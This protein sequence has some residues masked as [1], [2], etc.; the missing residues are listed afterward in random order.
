MMKRIGLAVLAA[1]AGLCAQERI[2]VVGDSITGHAMNLADG[3]KRQFDAALAAAGVAE[4]AVQLVPLGGSGQRTSTWPSILSDTRTSFALDIAS[5]DVPAELD[6]GCDKLVV[7]LG[8]NDMIFHEVTADNTETFAANLQ[9]LIDRLRART[10]FKSLY[11]ATPTFYGEEPETYCNKVMDTLASVVVPQVAAANGA[12]VIDVRAAF[13]AWWRTGRMGGDGFRMTSD[14]VHPNGAGHFAIALALLRGL[15]FAEAAENWE[16]TKAAAYFGD[17]A[18]GAPGFSAYVGQTGGTLTFKGFAN[19]RL[20]SVGVAGWTPEQAVDGT[21]FEIAVPAVWH[22]A[23]YSFKLKATFEDGATATRTF[24]V[25][26]PWRVKTGVDDYAQHDDYSYNHPAKGFHA[27]A[28]SAH[29]LAYDAA[30]VAGRAF[31]DI[32]P[33]ARPYWPNADH[34]GNGTDSLDFTTMTASRRLETCYAM[35]RLAVGTAQ[36]VKVTVA[37]KAQSGAQRLVAFLDGR[38]ILAASLATGQAAEVEVEMAAGE[39]EFVLKAVQATNGFQASVAFS[40]AFGAVA[41]AAS[42][43]GDP[44]PMLCRGGDEV[45]AFDGFNVHRFRK[46]GALTVLRGGTVELLLVGGGGGGSGS[47][48]CSGGGGGGGVLHLGQVRLEA[49][50]YAVCVGAGGASDANGGDT[51][52]AGFAAVGGGSGGGA[53][54]AGAAGGSGGGASGVASPTVTA[55]YAGGGAAEG[56]GF[57]GGAS[58]ASEPSANL[59]RY[60]AGGGGGAGGAG[61]DSDPATRT[62][63]SG[64]A[65]RA[66]TQFNAAGAEEWFAAGGGGGGSYRKSVKAGAGGQGGGGAGAYGM[67]VN[68]VDLLDAGG[69]ATTPGSGGGGGAFIYRADTDWKN[70]PG[71]KGADGILIVKYRA[72]PMHE[73][74]QATGGDEVVRGKDGYVTHVFRADGVFEA[75]RPGALEILVVGGGGGGGTVGGGG[76]GGLVHSASYAMS[77]KTFAVRVGRGGAGAAVGA[78]SAADGEDSSFGPVVAFGGGGGGCYANAS[79]LSAGRPGGSGGGGGGRVNDPKAYAGGAGVAGQGFAGGT[80]CAVT[81]ARSW[82]GGGGGG[83]AGGAGGDVDAA[84]GK[85]GDGGAGRFFP[86]FADWGAEG[87]FA[88]GGGGGMRYHAGYTAGAGAAGGGGG[89]VKPGGTEAGSAVDGTGSGGGGGCYSYFTHEGVLDWRHAAGGKGGSGIV[90]VRY[91]WQNDGLVVIV[92]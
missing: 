81:D 84:A 12:T 88:G 10:T 76:A 69:A 75:N 9:A 67:G 14:Y 66:F 65:G 11:L 3:Y 64:G 40:P 52:F 86:A 1:C 85:G 2:L 53:R 24:A 58:L 6:K 17:A 16:R 55:T 57:P 45:A 50:T 91:R 83:G 44:Q 48:G 7:F 72:R 8:M 42:G 77:E 82:A 25:G 39:H 73:T 15:G 47:G 87:W 37:C 32:F 74:L 26:T 28:E 61:G 13:R 51:V 43:G 34:F 46:D 35:R 79:S 27:D 38:E 31:A 68:N 49:G 36:T 18:A 54:G 41:A 63:G 30:L 23:A 80:G 21:D 60:A 20:R 71:G 22:N 90:I 29:Y 59:S 89:L 70:T 33:D 62:S 19:A 56:Q 78:E 92:R 4:G 5:V